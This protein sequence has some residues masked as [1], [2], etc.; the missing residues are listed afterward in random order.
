MSQGARKLSDATDGFLVGK[1][2]LLSDWDPLFAA[3]F[4]QTLECLGME[5]VKLLPRTPTLKACASYCTLFGS[6]SSRSTA[7]TPVGRQNSS[8]CIFNKLRTLR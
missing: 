4:L 6:D 5:A 2:Y 1:R 7:A 3:E 8:G